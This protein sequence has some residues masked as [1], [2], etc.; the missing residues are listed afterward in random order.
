MLYEYMN[1]RFHVQFYAKLGNPSPSELIFKHFDKQ[2][3]GLSRAIAI[4]PQ[5]H[6]QTTAFDLEASK[7][8]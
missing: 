3:C 2:K 8:I 5:A 6:G 7:K 4:K 1:C